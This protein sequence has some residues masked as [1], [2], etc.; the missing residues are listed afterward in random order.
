LE[1]QW[2]HRT[3]E[4][5]LRY[6]GAA[7]PGEVPRYLAAACGVPYKHRITYIELFKDSCE[8]VSVMVHVVAV[9]GLSR[10][11]VAAAIMRDRPEPIRCHE[12]ELV[13]PSKTTGRP[14]PQ[15]LKKMSSPSCVFAVG[16]VTLS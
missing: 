8:I 14:V 5:R 2:R 3:D 9:P 12:I 15:S 7:V 16:I 4:R 11:A 13:V 6:T 10:P 1:H